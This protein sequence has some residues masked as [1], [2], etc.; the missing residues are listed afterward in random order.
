MKKKTLLALL[1]LL[2]VAFTQSCASDVEDDIYADLPYLE[3]YELTYQLRSISFPIVGEDY[4]DDHPG[5]DSLEA[6]VKRLAKI[7]FNNVSLTTSAGFTDINGD[8]QTADTGLNPSEEKL[9]A[10]CNL[11]HQ[12]GMEISLWP[13][14]HKVTD[15][16]L[17]THIQPRDM[18][19]WMRDHTASMVKW[20][21]FAESVG[22]ER[23]I[24]MGDETQ[25]LAYGPNNTDLWLNLISEVRNVY[26]GQ[27]TSAVYCEARDNDFGGITNHI[28]FMGERLVMALDII[29]LC[30]NPAPLTNKNEPS[31]EELVAAW[32]GNAEGSDV[33]KFLEGIS[34]KY[35]KQIFIPDAPNHS[36]AGDNIDPNLVYYEN[37]P[38]VESQIEQANLI[39][40]A[41]RAL[42][43][44]PWF[45]GISFPNWNRFPL[46]YR[47]TARY[48][49][50][51]Y[52]E[53]IKGKLAEKVLY[54]Y[55]RQYG[56]DF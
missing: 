10:L 38:L 9:A 24:V 29:G 30:F 54:K 25:P 49:N 18:E 21:Q 14:V 36:Y 56:R 33:I 43:N 53:N 55:Y 42:N 27:I 19:E 3:D 47:F 13:F 11:I 52:G 48:L 1:V 22:V 37:I 5:W 41:I 44:K 17:D 40:A 2:A 32:S 39:E 51:E 28:D 31:V 23:F 6:T 34:Q 26:S 20:A 16:F 7:G 12:Y 50:S 46:D 45:L 35:G 8:Y 4:L 15:N